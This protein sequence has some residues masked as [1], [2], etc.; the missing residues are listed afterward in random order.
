MSTCQALFRAAQSRL[1][2]LVLENHVDGLN[3]LQF[4]MLLAID[5]DVVLVGLGAADLGGAMLG[6]ATARTTRDC[7]P[8]SNSGGR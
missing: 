1:S 5:D 3:Y 4:R 8:V 7:K 6:Q 2:G